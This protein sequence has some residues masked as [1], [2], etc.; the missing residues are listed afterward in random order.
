MAVALVVVVLL[1]TLAG[2]SSASAQSPWWH[3][4]ASTIPANLPR[5]GTGT[6]VLEAL[7]VGER[8]TSGAVTV[9]ATL[10]AGVSI[11]KVS[12]RGTPEPRV[13]LNA[14]A[15]SPG[16]GPA[17]EQRFHGEGLG[18]EEAR[19]SLHAC[20]EPAPRVLACTYPES[21]PALNP[22][23]FIEMGI[24][25]KIESGALSAESEVEVTG[26]E[27]PGT[28]VS[29][30][31]TVSSEETPFGVEDFAMVP[32]EEG[33]ALDARA[34]SHP[35]Q[36]T[37]TFALNQ[38]ADPLTPPALPR[39]LGFELPPGLVGNAAAIAQC[40]GLDFKTRVQGGGDLCPEA[41]AIGVATLTVDEPNSGGV[42]TFSIPLFN[43]TPE[44]GEPARFGFEFIGEL[45]TLGTSVRSGFDY[46]LTISMSNITE[47]ANF[48]SG[49]ITFWGVPGESSH[50]ASRGWGC[51]AGG[52]W[53]TQAGLPCIPSTE[54]QPPPFLTLPTSCTS[55]FAATLGGDSWP[56]KAGPGAEA[57]SIPLPESRYSLED[58]FGRALGITACNQLPFEPSIGASPDVQDASTPSGLTVNVKEPQEVNENASGVAESAV[59]DIAISLPEGVAL[60]PAGADGLEA[61]SE[62]QIGF[63]GFAE[64]NP[65]SDPAVK[66]PLF[67]STLPEPLEPGLNLGAEGFC[68]NASKIATVKLQTPILAHPIEGF[69]YLGAQNAN[70]FGSLIAVYVVAEDPVSGTLVKLA[71][72]LSLNPASGQITATFQNTPQIPIEDLELRFFGGE[73]AL[74]ATPAHCGSYVTNALF[75]PWSGGQP[76]ASTSSFEITSGPQVTSGPNGGAGTSGC[77]SSPLPFA[78]SMTG[79]T[80]SL[81]AGAFSPLTAT[82]GREDGQQALQSLR[83]R[84]PVGLSAMLSGVP[85]CPEAQANAGTCASAS[86][87]GQ[88]TVAAGLGADP[89][90]LAGG[91]VYLTEKYEGAPFGLSIVTPVKAGPLDLENT[92]EN[93]P[94]CDCLVIR[95]KI[96]VNPETA[97]L[98]IATGA[99]AGLNGGAS[100]GEIPTIIDG[101][102]LQIKHLNITINRAGFIL[103]PTNCA[104]L[105]LTGTISGNEG[106]IASVSSPF[107]VANCATLPFKPKLSAST[108]ANG[109]AVGHGASLHVVISTGSS[110]GAGTATANIANLKLDLPKQLPTRLTTLQRACRKVVF[111]A[112][113]A[114]CPASSIV[115]T[116]KAVTPV[117]SAAMAGPAYFVSNG[118]QSL[119]DIDIVLQ[120]DGV[121]LNLRGS[122]F[123]SKKNVTSVT[124]R[125]VPDIP[126]R[127]VELTLP[128]GRYS[129]LGTDTKLCRQKLAMPTALTGQNGAVVHTSVRVEVTGCPKPKRHKQK[130][131]SGKKR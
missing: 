76:V 2:A 89:Y 113:P 12:P 130:R 34:G 32:E 67:S 29:R 78:P 114:N 1:S 59:K 118:R 9:T 8:S 105:P 19:A 131:H 46:G 119:P 96:E 85:L 28:R 94:G 68:P 38:T 22:Y 82:I 75:A 24:A 54:N 90:T 45:V 110:A 95:A 91:K 83:L 111:T 92:P 79:G 93:H 55:P 63:E 39:N 71:G 57:T 64:L 69:V 126:L 129:A 103:N 87:I 81:N 58:G 40:S 15:A 36:L 20:N 27:A 127:S 41:T 102:P 18:P 10:P 53:A 84:L 13:S 121:R 23:E 7:N 35:F 112:N 115:G 104:H 33:G 98:T 48:I 6:V 86:E 117:L 43:L 49:T 47:L 56:L 122:T 26:G 74:L 101:I 124:F 116:V 5:G 11:E 88:T 72:E 3:V 25:V 108:R 60:N 97:Q 42:Q 107:Q 44:K 61:C 123:V 51:L 109:E 80:T 106:A 65:V 125:S 73:R 16:L 77:P 128:E 31:L 37:T 14:Y 70:P 21:F 99:R 4:T 30:P 120:G 52:H 50:D 62:S 66:A 17:E 100:A